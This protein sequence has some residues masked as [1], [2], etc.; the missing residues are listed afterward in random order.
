M[1]AARDDDIP[2]PLRD[3]DL[4]GRVFAEQ[5]Q[6]AIGVEHQVPAIETKDAPPLSSYVMPVCLMDVA[7]IARDDPGH[8]L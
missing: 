6:R 5:P 1:I 8:D 7:L 2:V 3:I 4:H